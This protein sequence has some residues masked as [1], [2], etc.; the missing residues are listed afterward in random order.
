[1]CYRTFIQRVDRMRDLLIFAIVF[2][3][4]L[5]AFSRPYIGVYLWTW[6]GLMNPHRL[7]WGMAYDFPFSAVIAGVTFA[8]I[9]TSKEHK[10]MVWSR[11]TIL[12]LIFIGWMLVTTLFA[13]DQGVALE[14]L[15]RVLKI[16]IFMFITI[17]LITDHKKL[18]I[19]LWVTVASLGYFGLK[20]GV[21][22]LLKGGVSRVYGPPGSFIEENNA[23][24]LALIMTVPL[25]GYLFFQEKRK[26]LRYCLGGAIF[27]T[28]LS[29]VG[30]QSRGA[31]LGII[32]M[33][34]FL[35]LK[36]RQKFMIGSI[37]AVATITILSLMPSSWWDRMATIQDYQQDTSAQGRINA[38]WTAWNVA[39]SNVMGGGLKM[40]TKETF[41]AYA[42]DPTMVFDAH[43]IYFQVLGEHGFIGLALFLSIGLFTWLRCNEIIRFCKK[44]TEQK[45]AAD[46]AGMLQVSMIGFATSGAFLS[47][48]YFD[49]YYHLIAITVITWNLSGTQ[50]TKQRGPLVR[51]R[52]HSES[53]TGRGS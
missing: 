36:S 22:T 51:S 30:S 23:L 18:T 47:L 34:G 50:A 42:P 35:W 8:G 5:K 39:K 20:G 2:W 4:L 41:L 37:V 49:Y 3:V 45:W 53:N 21:F 31:L 26:W 27:F 52:L 44:N 7:T 15:N 14:Y 46:L 11:E 16:L 24:A 1:M 12:L 13:F 33:G 10:R 6:M 25:I 9:F 40:F 32:V 43:S 28:I 48:A 29:I 19:L 17:Y 38:W